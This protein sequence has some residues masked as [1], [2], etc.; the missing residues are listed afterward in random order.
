M[1]INVE[2]KGNEE[3]K[4]KPL[5]LIINWIIISREWIFLEQEIRTETKEYKRERDSVSL[6]C[7]Y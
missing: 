2:A 1:N 3:L 5:L 4:Y 6:C 7:D